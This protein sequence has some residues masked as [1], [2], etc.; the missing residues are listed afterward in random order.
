MP[1]VAQR[2]HDAIIRGEIDN[3]VEG[4][5]TGKI[6]LSG[7][8]EPLTLDLAGD[9][10]RDLAG[11]H[12]KFTNPC[13]EGDAT[14][15]LIQKGVVG[16]MTASKK[17]R[18]PIGPLEDF[19]AREAAGEKP[20]C[21]WKNTLYLEWFSASNGRVVIEADDYELELSDHA[22]RMD[23]DAEEAQKLA[24]MQAM[25]DFLEGLISMRVKRNEEDR[26]L[27]WEDRLNDTDR[28]TDAYQEVIE[29]YAAD[30]DAEWKEAFVMGWDGF[31]SSF[32]D[33]AANETSSEPSEAWE[34]G[35]EYE[36]HPLQIAAEDLAIRAY[37]LLPE[38]QKDALT[39]TSSI[40]QV[41]GR[42]AAT[43]SGPYERESGFILAVLKRCLTLQNDALSACARL[44]HNTGDMEHLRALG[45]LRNDLLHLREKTLDLSKELR[46]N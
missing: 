35:D 16:D 14:L 34:D 31:L 13:P 41:A 19:L 40:G 22:W 26:D 28:L 23:A 1:A 3:T 21:L 5:T 42:L 11:A 8:R 25:R 17:C 33:D 18:V 27:E 39:I 30:P 45:A 24:N 15:A 43:L 12:L 46:K 2:I 20:P 44:L 9:C 7:M 36:S 37:D 29:K 6:W 32:S 4:T 38:D 10:W